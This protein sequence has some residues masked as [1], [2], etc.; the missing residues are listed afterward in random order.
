MAA[1]A[2]S[3]RALNAWAIPTRENGLQADAIKALIEQH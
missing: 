1:R 2:E 3:S